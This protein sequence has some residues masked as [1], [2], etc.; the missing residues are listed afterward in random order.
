MNP[1]NPHK[2]LIVANWKMNKTAS[3]GVD[4]AKKLAESSVGK[5]TG[6]NVVICP[7]FTAL[8]AMSPILEESTIALGGQ[9]MHSEAKGAYTGEVSA[10][11]LRDHYV[12]Y[13]ILGHSERREYFKEDNAFINKKVKAALEASLK[14]I[15]CVGEKLEE[16]EAGKTLDVVKKQLEEGLAG[17][18]AEQAEQLVI[19][20]EPV[21]AIGTGKTA[22]P[23]Q[24]EEVHAEIK[25]ILANLFGDKGVKVPVLYGGSMKPENAKELL[26]QPS[27]DGGLIGGASLEVKSF[28]GII[29]EASKLSKTIVGA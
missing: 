22:T 17:I 29:T 25:K 7:A 20:Y 10:K 9:N 4:F 15:L 26:E 6:V 2:Y 14:P 3:E 12:H 21:W 13:V 8:G 28:E 27:I 24:A 5:Q 18:K 16:R 19:A 23:E 11:M 1:Q